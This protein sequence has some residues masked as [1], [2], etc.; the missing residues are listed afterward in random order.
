MLL[1]SL[2]FHY[3]CIMII[4]VESLVRLNDVVEAILSKMEEGYSIVLLYGD[5]GSGKTT[6]VK[7]LCLSLGV[8]QEVTSPTFSMIQEYTSS[9]K[10]LIYHMDLYRLEKTVDLEH[11]GFGEYLDSGYPCFIEW[12]ALGNDYYKM[13]HIR[14]D[15]N[16]ENNNIRNFKITTYDSVDT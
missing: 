5:L 9:V 6:L 12:P 4:R 1:L 7:K 14:V 15:I 13:P 16:V 3:H 2:A 10:E 11:I 8:E